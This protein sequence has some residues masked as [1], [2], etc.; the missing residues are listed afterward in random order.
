MESM[1]LVSLRAE[2]R[3]DALEAEGKGRPAVF[4]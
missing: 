3:P 2:R 1:V 4:S